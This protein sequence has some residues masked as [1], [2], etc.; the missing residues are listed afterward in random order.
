L[1]ADLS[2]VSALYSTAYLLSFQLR[3]RFVASASAHRHI[4]FLKSGDFQLLGELIISSGIH[5][6]WSSRKRGIRAMKCPNAGLIF[7]DDSRFCGRL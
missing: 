7:S 3:I 4:L 2:S 6:I 1:P 5:I